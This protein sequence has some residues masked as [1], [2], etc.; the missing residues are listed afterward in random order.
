MGEAEHSVPLQH[1]PAVPRDGSNVIGTFSRFFFHSS[2]VDHEDSLK[3]PVSLLPDGSQTTPPS[4]PSKASKA[5][6]AP[7]TVGAAGRSCCPQGWLSSTAG[8]SRTLKTVS[9]P[10]SPPSSPSVLQSTSRE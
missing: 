2:S 1:T 4:C 8:H 5:L 3:T 9:P 7:G 10:S 6:V